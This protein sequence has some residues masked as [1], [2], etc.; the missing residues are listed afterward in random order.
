MK[1]NAGLYAVIAAVAIQLTLGIIYIWSVF[2]TGIADS[3][4]DGDNVAAGLVFSLLL[5]AFATGSLIGGRLTVR[6]SV[7]RVV[8]IGGIILSIGTFAASFVRPEFGWLLWFTYGVMGGLGMGFTYTTTI[9]AAQ[10]WYPHK[11]GFITGIIVAALGFGGVIFTPIIERLI[12]HFGGFGVGELNT[13]M[14]LAAIFLVVCTIGSI[15]IVEPPEGHMLDK[16]VVKNNSASTTRSFT[17]K[18]MIK[19][20]QF[21]LLT[22]AFVVAVI[23]GLMMIGFARPI[24]VAKGLESTATIGV[25]AIALFNSIG[26]LFWGMISD[27][28]GRNTTLIIL[29]VLSGIM[30]ISVNFVQGYAIYVLIALI[31]FSFGGILSNFPALTS[32]LFGAKYMAANY[33]VIL[34]GFGAGAII[35][36]QIAGHFANLATDDITLMFP[37]FII[38]AGFAAVGVVIMIILRIMAK[39]SIAK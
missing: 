20:P 21:Y 36:S 18:E 1:K 9:A 25:L 12:E 17:T 4:F 24:A 28:I 14:V 23:G 3:I 7:R 8:F 27:K 38:A 6:F 35:S 32:D 16:V 15:F 5:A 10:K 26:R 31:G 22:A 13:F 19:T 29:L 39:K 2:Q 33:G 30:S 34:L 11:K 37:A